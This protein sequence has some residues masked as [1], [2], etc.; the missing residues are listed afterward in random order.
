MHHSLQNLT[1]PTIEKNKSAEEKLPFLGPFSVQ[2]QILRRRLAR[3]RLVDSGK[4]A[5]TG[6]N[7]WPEEQQAPALLYRAA[8]TILQP[9]C[10]TACDRAAT[11]AISVILLYVLQ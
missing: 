1:A 9:S 5:Q 6:R 3:I 4:L 7:L 11:S 10:S 2:E 8:T